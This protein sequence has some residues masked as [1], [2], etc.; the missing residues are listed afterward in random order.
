[1]KRI[2]TIS[3]FSGCGGSD[4]AIKQ[5]G[6]HIVWANDID[7]VACQTYKDNIG[8]V[9]EQGDIQDFDFADFPDADFLVGCYPCQ[10]FTQGG[11][12]KTGDSIN[13][14]YQQFDRVLRAVLPRAFAVENV[15]GMLYGENRKLL[16]NQLYRYRMAGY[17][18]KW[19]VLDAQD[20]G[21]AQ[22]RRRIFIVGIRSDISFQY[23]FPKPLYGSETGRR[24]LSQKEVLAGMPQWPEGDFNDEP[25]HWYYLS[26]RRR[27]DWDEP[28][29][30]IVGHWRHVPLHPMSPPL[31]RIHTDKWV[32]ARKGPARRLSYRECAALQGFPKN[33]R[34]ERGTVRERFQLIGNAV[35]PPL[36]K[37][38]VSN[39]GD[40][41]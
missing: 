10:G 41:W 30:C 17:R 25:F 15:N 7:E 11:R 38:V 14:L 9:I 28:C 2:Q 37:A 8:P 13:F 16:H 5:L 31:K 26:R 18:V 21:V 35:P 34:W 39:L 27:H 24:P 1:M 40:L 36:F 19:Q 4:F 6:H 20:Y 22:Q 3:L 29:P 33:F 23:T 32:F 12:R